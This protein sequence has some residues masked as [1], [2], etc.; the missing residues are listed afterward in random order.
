M[1]YRRL[2]NSGLEVAV[3]GL[4]TA[5]F[6][7]AAPTATA[8][9][10]LSVYMDH[11]GNFIDT[12]NIYGGS[13]DND[14]VVPGTTETL[15]GEITKGRRH[16]LILATKGHGSV[17]RDGWPNSTGLS[18]AYLRR[19]LEASLR[20]LGTD[21]VDLYQF[22]SW[23]FYTPIEE[24]LAVMDELIKEGKVRYG[25]VSNWDG[26]HVAK[27]AA[28]ARHAG[29]APLISN[30]IFYNLIDRS[31]EN[32]I[33]PACQDAG[34][35]IMVWGPLA[36]GVLSGRFRRGSEAGPPPSVGFD[37][38]GEHGL[39][40]WKRLATERTWR[41]V[42]ALERIAAEHESTVPNVATQ[43]LLQDGS[44][45][46]VLIGPSRLEYVVS[47]L[48]GLSVR[49]SA[50]ERKELRDLS[51]PIPT[52]PVSMYGRTYDFLDR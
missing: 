28:H 15:V 40:S 41:I 44:C 3:L 17:D 38:E 35:G 27:A 14:A 32:S 2:G 11:G 48:E 33:I 30:Q 24:S 31:A 9:E 6:G 29:L 18:R 22:H 25:G 52:Y 46:L 34:V 8:N 20:R 5:M 19:E 36:Q 13:R 26:W 43:W 50:A 1:E 16:R 47:D 42:D 23:D 21:Y 10:I 51:R 7:A 39:T 4:G 45:D 12:A 49:L 37:T